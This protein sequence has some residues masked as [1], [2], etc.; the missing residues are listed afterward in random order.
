[1]HEIYD[2]TKL[3]DHKRCARAYYFRHVRHWRSE[4]LSAPLIFGLGW[5]SMM[6]VV[7]TRIND[8]TVKELQKEA[9]EAFGKTWIENGGPAELSLDDY[10]WWEPRVPAIAAEMLIKYI[11]ERSKFLRDMELLEVEQ[12]FVVPLLPG[13]AN[14]WYAGKKDKKIIAPNGDRLVVD[15]KTTTGYRKDGGF[16]PDYIESWYMNSQVFG[17]LYSDNILSKGN[18]RAVF[19]DCALVHKTVHDKFRFVPVDHKYTQLDMWLWDTRKRVESIREETSALSALREG[20]EAKKMKIMPVFSRN[21]ESCFGHYGQKCPYFNV[22][23]QYPNPEQVEAP[24]PQLV[25]E[26]W[27]PV[28]ML[29]REKL[30]VEI[31]EA[32]VSDK[33]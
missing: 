10:E 26:E 30:E 11:D 19:I 13:V 3:A 32:S 20:G 6:D 7:W 22:C 29:G 33:S 23:T 31:A 12:P 2:N 1:M 25:E 24:P 8:L 17:Y 21:E 4:G 5:H 16:K 15:H 9:V 28:S 18:T 27:N 14:V